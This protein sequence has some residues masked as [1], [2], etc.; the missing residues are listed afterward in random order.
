MILQM[1][2]NQEILG[3][4]V[5]VTGGRVEAGAMRGGTLPVLAELVTGCWTSIWAEVG[6]GV[7]VA[8]IPMLHH[9]TKLVTSPSRMEISVLVEATLV[10]GVEVEVVTGMI[11][12]GTV[13]AMGEVEVVIEGVMEETETTGEAMEETGT[14]EEDMEA[15]GVIEG[16]EVDMVGVEADGVTIEVQ[17][18]DTEMI[19]EEVEEEADEDSVEEVPEGEV[20]VTKVEVTGI[21]E[22]VVAVEEATTPPVMEDEL[23]FFSV[24]LFKT[25]D[26]MKIV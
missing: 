6:V 25:I 22:V 4:E 12:D 15:M 21:R 7:G 2:S 5:T 26:F 24:L 10:A 13:E 8:D 18:V 1:S 3:L 23:F 17:V 20:M 11:E 19:E 16:E 9:P 14:M